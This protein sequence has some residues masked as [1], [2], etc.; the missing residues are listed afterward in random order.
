M[1]G[2]PGFIEALFLGGLSSILEN[3]IL[4]SLESWCNEWI[5]EDYLLFYTASKIGNL[6]RAMLR[7]VLLKH[8]CSQ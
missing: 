6:A 5:K 4:K 7:N 2:N 1:V 8:K 3:P